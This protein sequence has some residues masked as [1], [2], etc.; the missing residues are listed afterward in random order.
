MFRNSALALSLFFIL[1]T[2]VAMPE[3]DLSVLNNTPIFDLHNQYI[4][5]DTD[6]EPD[7]DWSADLL[8]QFSIV[9][10]K[11][12]PHNS[13]YNSP[14]GKDTVIDKVKV[15][16]KGQCRVY[17]A[18]KPTSEGGITRETL[19][20]TGQ[21]FEFTV[22]N[23]QQPMW[24]E[25][26]EA[27][28]VTRADYANSPTRYLGVLFIKKVPVADN[29]SYV[30][31]VN[32]VSFEQYLK[33]VVPSEMPA[34][35]SHEA[36]KAQSI[37]ARTYA[38]YELGT[39]VFTKDSNITAEQSGAQM[40]DTVTYQAYLGLKN[41][42]AATDKAVDETAGQAMIHSGKLV[43]AYFHADSGG[44]TENAENV[45]GRYYPYIIGKPELY[46]DGSIPGTAWSYTTS[47]KNIQ[48][49]L[50]ANQLMPA[51]S[52]LTALKILKDD[53]FPST[54]PEFVTLVFTD[55]TEKKILAVDY[56]FATKIKSPWISFSVPNPRSRNTNITISG[57]GFG[58]GAGM[59]QW[60][61]KVMVDKLNKN[62]I[63][64]LNFYYTGIEIFKP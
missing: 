7:P 35:W 62:H 21:N 9:R 52:Q 41:T 39:K 31:L 33:G 49:Q 19:L 29:K 54:R 37:A 34:S 58:H 26:S 10:I 38:F 40:D 53:Y 15:S 32:V 5:I 13:K 61:A 11:I 30:T 36:L 2:A 23:I 24:L 47:L 16:S 63:E 48:D 46:P 12:F 44:H 14:H 8:N 25:C 56:A 42:T 22:A 55:K 27:F 20:M 51:N 50:V 28:Q 18:E 59:N 3:Q 1:S 4:E 60:G 6:M 57:R 17:R 45:W 64:I 43:K